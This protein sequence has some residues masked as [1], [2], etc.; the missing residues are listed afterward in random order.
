MSHRHP[1]TS[2]TVARPRG[3]TAS[4]VALGTAAILCGVL[5][6]PVASAGPGPGTTPAR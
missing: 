2:P 1:T 4:A 5:V 3:A 6:S